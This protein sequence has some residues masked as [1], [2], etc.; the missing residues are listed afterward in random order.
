MDQQQL[1]AEEKGGMRKRK[2]EAGRKTERLLEPPQSQTRR[3]MIDVN[4][5]PDGLTVPGG[6]LFEEEG[7]KSL[8]GRDPTD[9]QKKELMDLGLIGKDEM[10]RKL[11]DSRGIWTDGQ[12]HL[13]THV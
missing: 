2:V 6:T 12:N 4:R 10:E 9:I 7:E 8:C 13:N 1:V 5:N 11:G 3:A